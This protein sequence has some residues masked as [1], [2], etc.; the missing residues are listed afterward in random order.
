MIEYKM[1]FV[2]NVSNK[3]SGMLDRRM[4]SKNYD[5]KFYLTALDTGETWTADFYTLEFLENKLLSNEW[6]IVENLQ[7]IGLLKNFIHNI[8]MMPKFCLCGIQQVDLKN[9]IPKGSCLICQAEI[10]FKF[11]E[12]M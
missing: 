10:L 11:I 3:F 1:P 9:N 5:D 2:V 7:N 6:K 4:V 12:T 8:S